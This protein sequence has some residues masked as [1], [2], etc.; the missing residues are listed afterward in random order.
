[1]LIKKYDS[2]FVIWMQRY[3]HYIK[4]K[5]KKICALIISKRKSRTLF[6]AEEIEVHHSIGNNFADKLRLLLNSNLLHYDTITIS[7][8]SVHAWKFQMFLFRSQK[9]DS[10]HFP[11]KVKAPFTKCGQRWCPAAALLLAPY[12]SS[13]PPPPKKRKTLVTFSKYLLVSRNVM[14]NIVIISLLKK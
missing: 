5:Q 11:I 10:Y 12:Y 13:S 6:T 1:M 14:R 4:E 9:P 8:S 3:Y 7:F 2:S